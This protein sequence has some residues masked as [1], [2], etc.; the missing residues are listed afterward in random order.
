MKIARVIKISCLFFLTFLFSLTAYAYEIT[1]PYGWRT[2][3]VFGT[4]KFHTG[5][6]IALDYGDPIPATDSGTVTYAGY[7]E[8]YGNVVYI[9]HPDGTQT[10]YAHCE[11]LLVATGDTVQKNKIIALAGSTGWS[12]GPHLHIEYHVNG[13]TV[14]PVPYLKAQGWD[15]FYGSG[16]GFDLF[17]FG[18][19]NEVPWDFEAFFEI[20]ETARNILEDFSKKCTQG[21][22]LLRDEAVWLLLIL[23]VID[24]ALSVMLTGFQNGWKSYLSKILKYSIILFLVANWADFINDFVLSFFTTNATLLADPSGV[25][26]GDNV[27]DPSLIMQKGVFMIKPAFNYV[28]VHTGAKL[29]ANILDVMI[30]LIL[31]VG[32]LFC[33][34]LIGVSL[35]LIYLEFYFYALLSVLAVPFGIITQLKFIGERGLGAVINSGLR[36]MAVSVVVAI[37]VPFIEDFGPVEYSFMTYIKVLLA[38]IA[39]LLA[40]IR[41]PKVVTG[42]LGGGSPRL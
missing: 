26:I 21:L 31:A 27:S 14:D 13:E 19:Y 28:S 6:D 38:S 15:V 30:A 40:T 7:A 11:E 9:N 34:F 36:L 29:L 18:S 16:G 33:F 42:F 1:S 4:K 3:P 41:I 37:F 17:G 20:G 8:G 35:T 24:L 39:L 10:R 25:V 12:T 32:S 5:I 22:S 23:M 2:H